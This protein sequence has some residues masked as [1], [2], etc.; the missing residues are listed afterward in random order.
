MVLVETST[1]MSYTLYSNAAGY[2]QVWTA[3]ANSPVTLTVS[4][5][6]HVTA[7]VP[8]VT[9]TAGTTTTTDV[10][11]RLYA[12]CQASAPDAMSAS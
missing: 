5:P 8:G 9:A 10:K 1:G 4:A 3:A 6:G 12:P 11:L 2:Y 7:V